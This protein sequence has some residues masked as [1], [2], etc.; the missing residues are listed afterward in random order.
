MLMRLLAPFSM[1]CLV[2]LFTAAPLLAVVDSSD[3]QTEYIDA[4]TPVAAHS[5]EYVVD[6]ASSTPSEAPEAVASEAPAQPHGSTLLKP[7]R[8]RPPRCKSCC[9]SCWADSFN[10]ASCG[11]DGTGFIMLQAV[12]PSSD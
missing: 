3:S 8:T 11:I 12:N 10:V 4:T 2:A 6:V 7:R 9:I 5:Q 1:S